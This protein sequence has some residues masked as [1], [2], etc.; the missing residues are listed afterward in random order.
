MPIYVV[1][2]L[3]ERKMPTINIDLDF[4]N[5]PKTKRLIALAGPSAP[6]C[7]VTLWCYAAKYHMA[8]GDLSQHTVPE[9]EE[10][11]GWR[12]AKGKFVQA[13]LEAK[14]ERDGQGFL[15]EGTMCLHDWP[16]YEGHLVAYH[17]RSLK[18]NVARWSRIREGVPEGVPEGVQQGIPQ[19]VHEGVQQGIPQGV[20]EGDQQ[21]VHEG[22]RQRSVK[23][24]QSRAEQSCSEQNS[25]ERRSEKMLSNS[26]ASP[27]APA[28]SALRAG[29]EPLSQGQ[30][31]YE[32]RM[33]ILTN[34]LM[35]HC[36]IG[37]NGNRT[38]ALIES[39]REQA[40]R[41]EKLLRERR[42]QIGALTDQEL[43]AAAKVAFVKPKA[44]TLN[45]IA[46]FTTV[47][48]R[49][50]EETQVKEIAQTA[51]SMV[52]RQKT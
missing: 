26:T 52:G 6:H 48:Y 25:P 49:A 12:G 35:D 22:I 38:Q 45:G 33:Q 29:K 43:V 7:L 39:F 28:A 4:P 8:D 9:I 21:G 20:L 34:Y 40:G 41:F 42:P 16:V 46:A 32:R 51:R 17:E 10:F 19:G 3:R 11:A 30:A 31:E 44:H 47:L 23:E 13:L 2:E 14:K 37:P 5:H 24:S 27:S 1:Q 15:D 50:N 36:K 18:G